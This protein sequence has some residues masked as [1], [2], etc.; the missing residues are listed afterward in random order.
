MPLLL[1][2]LLF[3]ASPLFAQTTPLLATDFDA[4]SPYGADSFTDTGTASGYWTLEI[5]PGGSPSGN[6]SLKVTFLQVDCVPV[7]Q[8]QFG[9]RWT[10]SLPAAPAQGATRYV[11]FRMKIYDNGLMNW[12]SDATASGESPNN[13]S[14]PDKLFILGNLSGGCGGNDTSRVITHLRAPYPDR[15]YPLIKTEQGT[16]SGGEAQT[17]RLGVDSWLSIQIKIKSSSTTTAADAEISTYVNNDNESEPDHEF[18][19]EVITTNGWGTAGCGNSQIVFGDGSGNSL[20]DQDP[21]SYAVYE[22]ADFEFDDEFDDGWFGD[23][24]GVDTTDP[25]V[26]I[27]SPTSDPTDETGNTPLSIGGTCS[28]NVG[29]TSVTWVNAAGG[30]GT[31]TGTSVWSANIALTAGANAITVTCTDQSSNTHDDVITV[32]YIPEQPPGSGLPSVL[33]RRVSPGDHQGAAWICTPPPSSG[34]TDR[35]VSY[36]FGDGPPF[37][38]MTDGN[39]TQ[40][41]AIAARIRELEAAGFRV[42]WSAKSTYTQVLATCACG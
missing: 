22:L 16:F 9:P 15:D 25:V 35:G 1:I 34:C 24:S 38:R 6:S 41:V 32:T 28:D 18:D 31:A 33:P 23:L 17:E 37:E 14:A 19:G 42:G 39:A 13:R 29:I 27:T 36:A 30:S 21:T 5:V 7:C 26:T 11:R 10:S 2:V 4:P 20:S 12:R 40:R 8:R 3:W